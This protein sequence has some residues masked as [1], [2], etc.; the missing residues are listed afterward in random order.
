MLL[1]SRHLPGLALASALT[2]LASVAAAAP[3]RLADYGEP[4]TLL[5]TRTVS[6]VLVESI[7]A[8]NA[9]EAPGSEVAMDDF[10][11]Q[12]P[13]VASEPT[14]LVLTALGLMLLAGFAGRHWQRHHHRHRHRLRH[15]R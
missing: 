10:V 12:E 14:S 2:L 11:G 8:G 13:L 15:L 4:T 3:I 9:P 6:R 5:D 7:D 1:T